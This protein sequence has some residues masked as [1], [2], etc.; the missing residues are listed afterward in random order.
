L[1]ARRLYG[2]SWGWQSRELSSEC[3]RCQG[4]GT[5]PYLCTHCRAPLNEEEAD[6]VA[7]RCAN[8]ATLCGLCLGA[9]AVV[10][11]RG[12]LV[13]DSC[14]STLDGRQVA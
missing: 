4:T 3:P 13:C 8:C 9:E 11:V 14:L 6:S 10:Q 5:E 2:E 1:G 7:A 12:V